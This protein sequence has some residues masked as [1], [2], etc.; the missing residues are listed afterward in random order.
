MHN[1]SMNKLPLTS[2]V[3]V[4]R[5]LTE[6]NSLRSTSRITGV[7][8]NT[9]VKLL[10]D[11]GRAC[12]EYQHR[13]MR[14]LSC[15]RLQLDEIWAFVYAKQAN[16]PEGMENVPGIGSIWTWVALDADT[17]LV[18]SYLV[19]LRDSEHARAFV[20]DLAGRLANRVQIT[21]DGLRAYVGAIDSA[22]KGEVDYAILHKIYG[23]PRPD[24]A[25]YSPSDCLGCDKKP[26][27][28]NP[29]MS[30]ASTSFIERQNLTL[31]MRNRRFT[32]LTNAFSKK[33]ENHEHAIALYF[34]AYNFLQR[35]A[36]LR[37]PPAL[38]AGVT[39]HLWSY[40]ELVELIDR[41]EI[42]RKR[43]EIPN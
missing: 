1:V 42:E 11:A 17:K 24:E 7:A 38:F 13:V 33:I 5:C 36:T 21:T 2:R 29:D 39:D 15:R 23:T 32:R 12:A 30:H 14:N 37:M 3:S 34:F 6:G 22:F 31:R 10:I 9:V 4:L 25:R 19:G 26:A 18:P 43:G 40:E 27:I 41:H 20:D 28:G 8:F 35:H 16:I